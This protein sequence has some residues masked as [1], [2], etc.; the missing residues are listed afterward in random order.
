MQ[1]G[2]IRHHAGPAE[3]VPARMEIRFRIL[4][5][6]E[7]AL[8]SLIQE[9]FRV[10]AHNVSRNRHIAVDILDAYREGLHT[11]NSEAEVVPDGPKRIGK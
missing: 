1:C 5:E 8:D 7:L 11:D 3:T 2:A 10:L 6:L 9:V 4:P